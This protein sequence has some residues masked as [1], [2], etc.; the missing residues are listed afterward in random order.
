[1]FILTDLRV[2]LRSTAPLHGLDPAQRAGAERLI[3]D[4]EEQV[5]IIREELIR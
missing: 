3:S 5:R 2:L 4:L 1:M